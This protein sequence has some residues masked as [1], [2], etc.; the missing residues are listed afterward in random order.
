MPLRNT[1]A[2]THHSCQ[3]KKL[4]AKALPAR[5]Y[6]THSDLTSSTA[7]VPAYPRVLGLPGGGFRRGLTLTGCAAHQIWLWIPLCLPPHSTMSPAHTQNTA[8]Q[9]PH[10][11]GPPSQ[12]SA[13]SLWDLPSPPHPPTP[14]SQSRSPDK[15]PIRGP[16]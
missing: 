10:N 4:T 16:A 9:Q 13:Q 6:K 3:P 14:I 8:D 5:A 12:C 2:V 7:L 1:L 15:C 11:S